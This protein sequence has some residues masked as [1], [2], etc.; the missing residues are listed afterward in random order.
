MKLKI[1]AEEEALGFQ[2]APMID[3]VFQL[4]IFFMATTTLAKLEVAEGLKLPVAEYSQEKQ[5]V[6]NEVIINVYTDGRIFITPNWYSPDDLSLYLQAEREE[7]NAMGADLKLYLRGDRQVEFERILKV[8]SI[9]AEAGI[10]DVNYGVYQEE[11]K[12]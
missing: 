6:H 8:M 10:W 3:V 5:G 12:E 7:A 4:I 9:C 1:E 11:P 2:M